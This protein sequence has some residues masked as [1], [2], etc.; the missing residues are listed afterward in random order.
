MA[1]LIHLR[2][3]SVNWFSVFV[4]STSERELLWQTAIAESGLVQARRMNGMKRRIA[5]RSAHLCHRLNRTRFRPIGQEDV[6]RATLSQ[7]PETPRGP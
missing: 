4:R 5:A 1:D 2:N 6:R 7:R 3:N